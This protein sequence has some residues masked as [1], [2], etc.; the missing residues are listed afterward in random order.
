M[1]AERILDS[2]QNSL[3]NF[4]AERVGH[5]E[6]LEP[7]IIKRTGIPA[8]QHYGEPRFAEF[9]LIRSSNFNE[10]RGK[11]YAGHSIKKPS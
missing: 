10:L 5:I 11:F 2:V 6:H 3:R 7:V 8:Q 1:I 9:A 4:A